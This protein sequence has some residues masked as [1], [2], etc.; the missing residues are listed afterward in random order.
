MGRKR[1]EF[2][3]VLIVKSSFTYKDALDFLYSNLDYE[4]S[5]PPRYSKKKYDLNRFNRLL[6]GLGDPHK[7]FKTIHVA[8]TKGKGSTAAIISSILVGSGYKTGLYTSPH[9]ISVRERICVGNKPVSASEFKDAISRIKTVLTG[10]KEDVRDYATV[11]EIL[12]AASFLIFERKKVDIAIIEAGL[13]GR[14]D[15]TNVIDPVISVI[16]PVSYD[17]CNVLGNSL[18]KIAREKAGII[19]KGG[20][21]VVSGQRGDVLREIRKIADKRTAGIVRV[22]DKFRA[23]EIRISPAGSSFT[24]SYGNGSIPDLK[25]PL[26]GRHQIE[27]SLTAIATAKCIA[28]RPGFNIPEK[29]IRKGLRSVN[30]PGRIEV[31]GAR[32]L[33]ILDGAHNVESIRA[34]RK[35]VK[36]VFKYKRLILVFGVSGDKDIGGM[37]REIGPVPDIIIA[38]RAHPSRGVDPKAIAAG[39][40]RYRKELFVEDIPAKAYRKA[41]RLAQ[42]DDLICV[43]GSLYL[44]GKILGSNLSS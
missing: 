44:A 13:G 15:A 18:K 25:I 42:K 8:G 31:A 2:F 28:G 39:F 17:H 26:V 11:F 29:A 4:K 1:G 6:A 10:L 5:G 23:E 37:I 32:P 3:V 22:T 38:T 34:L 21:V 20:T 12:T 24:L 14:L 7:N 41:V 9:L 16:T 33:I 19:K 35:T 36:D 43:T 30:W 40:G 27:N